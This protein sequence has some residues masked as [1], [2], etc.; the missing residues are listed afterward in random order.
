MC[1]VGVGKRPNQSQLERVVFS[2]AH[3]RA[4]SGRS[5]AALRGTQIC[6]GG[7]DVLGGWYLLLFDEYFNTEVGSVHSLRVYGCPPGSFGQSASSVCRS[8]GVAVPVCCALFYRYFTRNYGVICF[9]HV[10]ASMAVRTKQAF[11]NRD[12][13]ASARIYA[14]VITLRPMQQNSRPRHHYKTI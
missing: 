9:K 13:Q 1:C 8:V 10:Y 2:L 11:I 4:L 5:G 6:C 12:N 7:K 3:S 14:H